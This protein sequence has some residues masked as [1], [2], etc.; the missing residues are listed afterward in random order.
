MKEERGEKAKSVRQNCCVAFDPQKTL[1]ILQSAQDARTKEQPR[2]Q[3]AF[4]SPRGRGCK[5][6]NIID[7]SLGK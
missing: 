6:V 4:P 3:G 5:E 1:E 2:P 7:W